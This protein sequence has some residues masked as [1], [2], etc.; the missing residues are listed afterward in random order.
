VMGMFRRELAMIIIATPYSTLTMYEDPVDPEYTDE[1]IAFSFRLAKCY[2]YPIEV[3]YDGRCGRKWWQGYSWSPLVERI[4][5]TSRL[6]TGF[7]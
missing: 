4:C 1:E 7:F 3:L 6:T 5:T 2:G